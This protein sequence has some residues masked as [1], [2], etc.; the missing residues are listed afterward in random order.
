MK[1]NFLIICLFFISFSALIGQQKYNF[2]HISIPA[3]LSN[4]Q[5][6]DILQDKYGFLWVAT[7]DG[8]NCYDGYSFKV[9]KND[10][11]DLKSLSNNYVYSIMIDNEETLWVGTAGGL[12]KYDRANDSFVNFLPDSNRANTSSNTI[13]SIVQDS[14]NRI[15]L[16]TFDGIF[17]FDRA[18]KK[19]ERTFIKNGNNKTPTSGVTVVLIET[20][21]GEIYSDYFYQGIIKYNE[22]TNLFELVYI[23]SEEPNIFK[24]TNIFSLYED[25][26]GK[27]WI[28]SQ[29]G[30]YN[31]DPHNK[32]FNEINLFKKEKNPGIYTNAVF[33][34]RQESDGFLW[35]G[36]A[37]NGIFRYNMNT[38]EVVKLN[39]SELPNSVHISDS[40]WKFYKDEFG[41]L[42]IATQNNGLL[43]LD[44]QKEPFRLFEN[45][46]EKVKSNTG[47]FIGSIYKNPVDKDFIWLGTD[48]GLVKYYLTTKTFNKYKHQEGNTKSIPSNFVRSIQHG[49]AQELWLGTNKGLSLMNLSNNSFTN[50]DLNEKT[51]HYSID[52]NN[53][54]N[55]STDEYG[56][57]WVA[58]GITGLIKF[59]TKNKTKQFIPTVATRAY[60]LRLLEFIDSLNIKSKAIAKLTEVGDYQD[61]KKEFNLEKQTDIMI[62]SAGE[63]LQANGMMDYGWLQD[64]KSDTVWGQT[65]YNKSFYLGGDFKNRISVEIIKLNKGNYTLRYKSDDSHSYGKWNAAAP[66]DSTLW[67]IQVFDLS[68]SDVNYY[69]DQIVASQNKPFINGVSVTKVEYQYDGTVLIGTSTGLSEYDIRKNSIKYLQ[70]DPKIVFTQ[71]LKQIN[72]LFV[73][74]NRTVWIATNGGL[75]KYDQNSKQFNVLYDKDGLPSNYIV[76]IEEDTYGNLWLSTLNGISKFNKDIV[77]PIFINYDVKDGLQ[78]YTFN[79]RASFK[80]ETGELFFAGQNGFNAF[81]SGNINKQVPKIDITQLKISNELVYPSTKN[82]PL[83]K[84]ILD[85]KEIEIAYSQNNISFEFSAI[86]FSRP[87]KN[88]YAYRLDGFDKE[89]WIYDN[90]KFASYTNLPLGEYVFRVKGSNGDGVWNEAGTSIKIKVLSPWWR[91]IW[92]Y[93]GYVFVFAGIILG[94]D[95][96]QRRRLLFKERERQRFHNAELRAQKAELQAKASEAERRALEIENERKSKELESARELQLSMLPKQLP[97]FPHLD[98]AVYMK[99]ATE[100]GGDYYD[101]NVGIDGTLTVVLGDATGHGMRAGTM[102][103]SAKSLFNS[104]AANPDILF[105]FRE[106]TRCIKKMQFQSLAMCMTM[107]KIQNNRLLMSAAG[108]PPVYLFR[109]KNR[110]IEEHL[111]KGMP[112][113]TMDN[114]PY[115]LKEMEL[116]KGDTLLLMSD[117][118]PELQNENNEIYGYKRA[119]NSFEE[120][121]EKDPEEIISYLKEEGSRWV[122][123]NNPDDDVTFVVIKVK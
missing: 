103:T 29:N 15:W 55:L 115:E 110:I 42:W 107:L 121:A 66:I 62:V 78:G 81:H 47:L 45:P 3:G 116:F 57:L 68:G 52:Y 39:Q 123:D 54:L 120:V 114:F 4:T 94:I 117:G 75:I 84:S 113:G 23:S 27:I 119:R 34:I 40:F 5:V 11:G 12:C 65:N 21:S 2:E 71:N 48:D 76:A 93:I 26:T 30:L 77:H 87:E 96:F 88:Q 122:N 19:F 61:L 28:G 31:Y 104:Y 7:A 1:N 102:V 73:D 32:I 111:M 33:G 24:A 105:T 118:F 37:G 36:S 25:K 58:S 20:S 95:R 43:K 6:W 63:G 72:D 56:N 79:R 108:M 109:N 49:S 14:K 41:I 16:T 92:A 89:G 13:I 98:I 90:R 35:I 112:L 53:I 85:T 10:P 8:L 70:N 69:K 74:K 80:S 46:T 50:F 100:V 38:A 18:S 59:D 9:Y 99:T 64:S 51:K 60:D 97:Q 101:F 106:M 67:G 82:S 44:F 86:H 22:S 17:K 83:I 91:T